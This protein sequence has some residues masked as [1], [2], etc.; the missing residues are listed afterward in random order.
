M[1]SEVKLSFVVP[2]RDRDITRIEK[3]LSSIRATT[4]VPFEFI[5][6]DYGSQSECYQILLQ[7]S[8]GLNFRVVRSEAQGLPWN[9][10]HAINNGVRTSSAPLIVVVDA[11]MIFVDRSID[12][13]LSKIQED[14]V[15]FFESYWPQNARQN[16]RK[17]RVG[18][19]AGAFMMITR[20][21]FERL[22]G[23]CEDFEFWG[24]ED[25]EW[26]GR[27]EGAGCRVRWLKH[28]EFSL[29][30]TWHKPEN[31]L[32]RRPFTAVTEA[33]A[34]ECRT[35]WKV[36]EN[37]EWGR[38]LKPTDRPVLSAMQ[39]SDVVL[40]DTQNDEQSVWLRTL[41]QHLIQGHCVKLLLGPR[42]VPR[43]LMRFA[44]LWKFVGNLI[45]VFSLQLEVTVN[46]R[47]ETVLTFRK[48]IGA[49]SLDLF[50][51]SDYSSVYMVLR[52]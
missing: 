19:S 38:L 8:E 1:V 2:Y 13:L 37:P 47:L 10:A 31:S 21:W 3:L 41:K 22:Q 20:D 51:A 35:I 39:G 36:Y 11:D 5:V 24:A 25:T 12:F 29:F 32:I 46:G 7:R 26:V 14:E 15:W 52:R 49:E 17:G 34:I 30:H 33:L 9:R 16:P 44:G 48:I 4:Q 28:Q 27:L 50:I 18:R 40:L 42:V 43:A 45:N 6:S 23:M